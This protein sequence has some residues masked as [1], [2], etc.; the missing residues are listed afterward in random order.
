MDAGGVEQ[1]LDSGVAQQVLG[2]QVLRQVDEHLAARHL[3]AMDVA[4]EL[5]LRLHCGGGGYSDLG[6]SPGSPET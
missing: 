3:V 2:A 1:T 4:D 5:H 6:K